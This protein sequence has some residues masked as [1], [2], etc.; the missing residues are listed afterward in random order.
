MNHRMVVRMMIRRRDM[1]LLLG[2]FETQFKFGENSKNSYLG[3]EKDLKIKKKN[4]SKV[5]HLR[6]LVERIGEE[7]LHHVDV[8]RPLFL[9][10]N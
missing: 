4:Y 1:R 5:S 8:P 7:T 6:D 3:G 10:F 2:Y 9:P